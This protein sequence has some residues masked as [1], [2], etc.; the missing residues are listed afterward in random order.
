MNASIIAEVI[1]YVLPL[2]KAAFG[3]NVPA[4]IVAALLGHA[5]QL[6]SLGH[7]LTDGDAHLSVENR[8]LLASL[9][10]DAKNGRL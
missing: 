6:L 10:L 7:D 9:V 8:N 2:L 5:T 4:H 1:S 3:D